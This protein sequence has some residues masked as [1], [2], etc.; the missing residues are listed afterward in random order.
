MSL[1]DVFVLPS[2]WEGLPLG[3]DRGRSHGKPIVATDIG[4]S[5]EIISHGETGLLVPPADP[6]A[7]AAAVNRLLGD[8]ALSARLA[9]NAKSSI[10]PR[11]TL[12]RMIAEYSEI[13]SSFAL[14]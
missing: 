8:P 12:E 6:A 9:A 13:Y 5:R 10:P 1:F 14:K 2:L 11:F 7:L 4:G 3:P